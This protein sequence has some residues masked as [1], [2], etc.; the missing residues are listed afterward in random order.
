MQK[1]IILLWKSIFLYFWKNVE[2]LHFRCIL[3][4]ALLFL[5]FWYFIISFIY[6]TNFCFSPSWK[7]LYQLRPYCCFLLLKK[8]VKSFYKSLL[9]NE[10]YYFSKIVN[11]IISNIYTYIYII[12]IIYNLYNI[13]CVIYIMYMYNII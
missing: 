11:N 10:N 8:W 9:R 12:Y 6:S 13:N 3:N 4:T 5:F 7:F 1:F 2:V